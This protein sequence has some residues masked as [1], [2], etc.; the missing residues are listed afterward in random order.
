MYMYM[1]NVAGTG[2]NVQIIESLDNQ[3]KAHYS[4]RSTLTC[5]EI[6]IVKVRIIEVWLYATLR[7]MLVFEI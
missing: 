2:Q 1:Y 5:V 6:R 7:I 3:G 4:A